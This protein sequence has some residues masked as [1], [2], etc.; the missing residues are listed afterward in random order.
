MLGVV[1]KKVRLEPYTPEWKT[2]FLKEQFAATLHRNNVNMT[3]WIND[4]C[5][6]VM[7]KEIK[8]NDADKSS[9]LVIA[10]DITELMSEKENANM[11]GIKIIKVNKNSL[12]EI[13]KPI[14]KGNPSKKNG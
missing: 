1:S 4:R 14:N 7:F 10:N 11:P 9:V 5:F 12:N 3:V 8:I 6:T 13:F 2:E